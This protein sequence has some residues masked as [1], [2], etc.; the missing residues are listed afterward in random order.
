ME[1]SRHLHEQA[2]RYELANENTPTQSSLPRADRDAMAECVEN[3]RMVLGILGYPILEP[4]LRTRGPTIQGSPLTPK[5]VDNP[6]DELVLRVNNITA[7]GAVT[8]EGFVIKKGS[9][10]A[11][12]NT[13]SVAA[14][15]ISAKERYLAEGILAPDGDHLVATEDILVSSS[16]YAAVIVAGTSRSG[17]QSWKTLDG[18]TL[19]EIEDAAIRG[20]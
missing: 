8:D 10:A 18:K 1:R 6:V 14:R 16:S 3:S 4:L 11:R 9:Q 20:A 5:K 15:L 12:T 13:E 17:P 19:K 7:S 2:D